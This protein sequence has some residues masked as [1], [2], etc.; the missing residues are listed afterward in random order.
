[1]YL[2]ENGN[3]RYT[4]IIGTNIIGKYVWYIADNKNYD[5]HIITVEL[6]LPILLSLDSNQIS[7]LYIWCNKDGT[8]CDALNID[9]INMID[10]E[11]I[12][13]LYDAEREESKKVFH[14][15]TRFSIVP[16]GNAYRDINY[17]QIHPT[18]R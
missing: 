17:S 14:N 1:M 18:A 9:D 3:L 5:S 10:R 8:E 6:G 16:K 11:K 15:F 4:I 2:V 7:F 13:K 12:D